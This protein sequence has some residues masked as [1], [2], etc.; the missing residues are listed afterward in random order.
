M[1]LG[2]TA[3]SA[4]CAHRSAWSPAALRHEGRPALQRTWF[5]RVTDTYLRV[6]LSYFGAHPTGRLLAHADADA[7]RATIVLQPLPLSLGVVVLVGLSVVSLALIDPLLML[8]GLALF[9][10][11]ALLNHVYSRRIEEPAARAQARL[12][13]VSGVAHE[14][15]DGALVVKTLGLQDRRST[16]C[17]GP[18][19]GC[20]GRG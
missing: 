20:G 2:A 14:S 6:P 15:F 16:A 1:A 8:V 18:P 9:P 10:A 11:L 4:L 13:E 5:R 3:T 19:T 12:G 7:E 17:D